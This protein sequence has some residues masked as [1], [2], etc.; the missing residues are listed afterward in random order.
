[1][2]LKMSQKM[3]FYVVNI[4]NQ[5]SNYLWICIYGNKFLFCLFVNFK[6]LFILFYFLIMEHGISFDYDQF[7]AGDWLLAND[8]FRRK[9]KKSFKLLR[10][11]SFV[12]SFL[13]ETNEDRRWFS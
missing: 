3:A 12:K 11:A 13:V 1:M 6:I 2:L 5:F 10:N 7:W 4:H 8:L 9:V